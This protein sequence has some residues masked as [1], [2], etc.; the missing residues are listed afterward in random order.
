M[1]LVNSVTLTAEQL[2]KL[3]QVIN[4]IPDIL[5]KTKSK[6][7]DEIFG[8]RIAADSEEHVDPTMRNEILLKFLVANDY[9]VETTKSKLVATLDWR[10]EFK[11]L[12]AAYVEKYDAG[13]EK[14]GVITKYAEAPDN[15]HVA[16][17]NLYAN[18][19]NPKKLFAKFGVGI[20]QDE[21]AQL[22]G[23]MFLRWRIGLMERLLCLLD[24]ADKHNNKAAQVH[25]YNNVLM[26]RM[27]PGM[28][29]ATNEIITVFQENYPELLSKKFFVNVPLLMG[30]V[31]TFFKA[32]GV[33]SAATV[34]RFEMM[35]HGDLTLTFNKEN[36]P[37]DYNGLV[38]NEKV[39]DIFAL[40]V[41]DQDVPVPAY[42]KIIL[43]KLK[44]Q[45]KAEHADV[46]ERPTPATQDPSE[47]D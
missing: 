4:A 22:P 14:L 38:K 13:L 42:A 21:K 17:W 25:D 37:Y 45:E 5:A 33:I 39:P 10:A 40:A 31:F 30:W 12:S 6:W 9:N 20:E 18:L 29:Q 7:Y 44:A 24:F 27:D 26:F 3:Q 11:P 1:S 43:E 28:K 34:A 35:N 23:T 47:V 16:T 2:L 32:T 46:G 41:K 19:K 15:F 36:L 8:F